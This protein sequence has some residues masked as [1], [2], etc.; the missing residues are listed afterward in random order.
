M[1]SFA[2]IS[3]K[4]ICV[5]SVVGELGNNAVVEMSSPVAFAGPISSPGFYLPLAFFA[6]LMPTGLWVVGMQHTIWEFR[7]LVA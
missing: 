4:S 6:L 2:L 3:D 5:C 7:N 1:T